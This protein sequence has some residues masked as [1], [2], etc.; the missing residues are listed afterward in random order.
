MTGE[1]DRRIPLTILG[2]FLGSGKT[3]WIRHHL[4]H[5]E[6]ADALL[7]VNEAADVPVDDMLLFR[8]SQVRVLAGGCACCENREGLIELLR[9]YCDELV[10]PGADAN[11]RCGVVLETSGLA[12][13]GPIVD[14]LRSDPVL[15]HHL[16]VRDI[17]VAVD[18]IHGLGY[19]RDEALGRRQVESADRLILT[20]ADA[21]E[22]DD[23]AHLAATLAGLNPGAEITASAM[24]S[25]A[26][27]PEWQH[28]SPEPI[29]QTSVGQG[30]PVISTTLDLEAE[31]DWTSFGVWL[32]ALLHA[33]GEDIVRVKGIVRT[34]SGRLLL[35]SVRRVVQSPE[36]LPDHV[37]AGSDDNS[38]VF[39]GRGFRQQ[40]LKRSLKRFTGNEVARARTHETQLD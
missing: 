1:A 36:I 38:L 25:P 20:K 26:P 23:L 11:S 33:R 34:P 29:G 24:G 2:G 14:A 18:A 17:I 19:L 7:V 8:S 21:V 10:A 35:Q 40:D 6:M 32:S 9:A 5:G 15:T 3:T 22:G 27:L 39:I 13:P 28:L 30:G 31:D 16:V 37:G 4:H 12:D